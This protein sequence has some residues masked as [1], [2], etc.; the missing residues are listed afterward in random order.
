MELFPSS[1]VFASLV[2]GDAEK[3]WEFPRD[4]LKPFLPFLCKAVFDSQE[5][6]TDSSVSSTPTTQWK[7]VKALHSLLCEMREVNKIKKYLELDFIELKS[8][9]VKERQL[10]AK[11]GPDSSSGESSLVD[12]LTSPNLAIEF[13]KGSEEKQFRLV[14]SEILNLISKVTRHTHKLIPIKLIN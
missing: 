9:A 3:L 11:R 1:E 10:I 5:E 8:D 14:L 4:K 2:S 12:D 6:S 7:H 13:E